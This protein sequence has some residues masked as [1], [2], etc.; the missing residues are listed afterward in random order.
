MMDSI[1]SPAFFALAN[2]V[3]AGRT[4]L[5]AWGAGL[6][7][8]AEVKRL[9]FKISHVL[10][11]DAAKWGSTV[12]GIRVSPPD[13]LASEDSSR[14]VVLLFTAHHAEIVESIAAYG[15]FRVFSGLIPTPAPVHM[16][17]QLASHAVWDAYGEAVSF[18]G[19]APNERQEFVRRGFLVGSFG[20]NAAADLRQQIHACPIDKSDPT[21]R[22]DGFLH[23]R[24]ASSYALPPTFEFRIPTK[25][26]LATV[27]NLLGS[28]SNKIEMALGHRIRVAHVQCWTT[29]VGADSDM[30]AL[31]TDDFPKH[32]KKV[33]IYPGPVD[34]EHGTT[35]IHATGEQPAQIAGPAGTWALL[36]VDIPHRGISPKKGVRPVVAVTLL[37]AT[38]TDLSCRYQPLPARHPLWPGA[39]R[40]VDADEA[41]A[42]RIAYD[43]ARQSVGWQA[44]AV[45]AKQRAALWEAFGA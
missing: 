8:Q 13:L 12:G 38:S 33:L 43:L 44:T 17:E 3:R 21:A 18:R 28:I 2:D 16:H 41:Y 32:V 36:D 15:P 19:A 30:A 35:E 11:R 6:A 34:A 1:F 4:H 9:P 37:P 20:E 31:H 39:D 27:A 29:G 45:E 26:L 22:T 40:D 42:F 24:Y 7:F 10:D 14:T 23:T 5:I 25:T